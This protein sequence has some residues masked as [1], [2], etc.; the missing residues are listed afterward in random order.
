MPDYDNTNRFTLFRNDKGGN[1]K[2]PDYTGEINID[3]TDY[4]LSAWIRKSKKGTTYMSGAVQ[5]KDDQP[6]RQSDGFV[7][8]ASEAFSDD[9]PF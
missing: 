5:P 6:K 9:I 3:G 1:D 7:G 4:R 2:R 8:K